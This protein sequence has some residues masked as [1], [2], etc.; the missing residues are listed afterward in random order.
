[1]DNGHF[2]LG[3]KRRK[4]EDA[5]LTMYRKVNFQQKESAWLE[6]QNLWDY[7]FAWYDLA[8]Y[9]EDT[10]QDTAIGAHMLDLYLDCARLFRAAATDGKLKE[11]RRDKAADALFQLNYYFN[12]LALNVERNVNQHNADDADAAGRI[13][14]KN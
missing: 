5:I 8:K 9:Y 6:D 10:P 13:G 2:H 4:I 3:L 11:R 14:W 7:I 12:Q 1:M